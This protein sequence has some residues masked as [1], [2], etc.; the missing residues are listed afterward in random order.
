[1]FCRMFK[2]HAGNYILTTLMH[3]HRMILKALGEASPSFDFP[4]EFTGVGVE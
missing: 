2:I 4:E 3:S 1:M